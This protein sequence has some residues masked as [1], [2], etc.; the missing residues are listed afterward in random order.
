VLDRSYPLAELPAA[1]AHQ[2]SGSVRGKLA[3]T[4]GAS[5]GDRAAQDGG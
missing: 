1:L 4:I 3:I 2:R 5:P